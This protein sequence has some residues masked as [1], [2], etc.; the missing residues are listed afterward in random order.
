MSEM[1]ADPNAL[2]D[3]DRFEDVLK[4]YLFYRNGVVTREAIQDVFRQRVAP[5]FKIAA[6]GSSLRERVRICRIAL[7]CTAYNT[8]REDLETLIQRIAVFVERH[9]LDPQMT[10]LQSLFLRY[11]PAF[12][13]VTLEHSS[14]AL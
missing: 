1:I 2:A 6:E 14:I 9:E 7:N 3:L 11:H 13:A 8:Q 4:N 12:K 10:R 5:W